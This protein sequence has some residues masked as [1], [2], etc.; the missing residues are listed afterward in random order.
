MSN[1]CRTSL[2]GSTHSRDSLSEVGDYQPDGERRMNDLFDSV[3]SGAVGHHAGDKTLKPS[4]ILQSSSAAH[5]GKERAATEPLGSTSQ[6]KTL[7]IPSVS[8]HI[9]PIPPAHP[10]HIPPHLSHPSTAAPLLRPQAA[11][12]SAN[13]E[14]ADERDFRLAEFRLKQ[15]KMV[16]STVASL[17]TA[18]KKVCTLEPDG[19]NF[20]QWMRG[21]K[22]ISRTGLSGANFFFEP[23]ENRTFERIGRAVIIASVHNSLVPDLHSIDT[24]HNMYLSLKKKFK[25]VSRAAQL[26]IWRRFMAFKVDPSTPSAGVA[27]TLLDL[28]SEWR[29][30]NI[31]CRSDSF[32]GFILQT[33]VMQSGAA[34][35]TDFENRI[36]NAVQLDP[37]G[38]CPTFASICNA[39]DICRQQH[40]QASDQLIPAAPT[41][42]APTALLTSAPQ[43]EDFDASMF[44]TGIDQEDWCD[45]LDFFALTAAKCW[46]CGGDNHY[47]RDCPQRGRSSAQSQQRGQPIG[48]L[49]GTIYGQLPSGFQ[50]TSSRFPNYSA[51]KSLAPPS[52]GQNRARQIADYYRPRYSQQNQPSANQHRLQTSPSTKPG[53]G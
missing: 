2:A 25:T 30:V 26:N 7:P 17:V 36:E 44:L 39:Y 31:S 48:T 41:P 52:N 9:P 11:T 16:T 34:Y 37:N 50:V 32:L 12:A 18:F 27:A 40:L 21:L 4:T 46:G 5:K 24:A 22:E 10:K 20:S 1:D 42:Y 49:V 19:T 29:S 53:G 14:T 23:C 45:A 28:Y 3:T 15:N 43:N 33:A 51:R 13:E 6:Q 47:Q 38:A 8:N 35:R